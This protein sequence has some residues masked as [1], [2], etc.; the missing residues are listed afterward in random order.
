MVIIDTSIWVEAFRVTGSFARRELEGLLRAREAAGIGIIY[1]EVLRGAR[2]EDDF[3]R[4]LERFDAVPFIDATKST[5]VLAGRLLSHLA[6]SGALIP[7]P[8]AVI[9]AH[10]LEGDHELFT[11][12]EH[13]R[14]VP[15][16]R[17]HNPAGPVP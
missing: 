4:L 3:D 13:F 5:W 2:T 16:L 1:A 11:R 15:G 10:A 17:L 9:A 12:D 6:R 14:R 7:L 8:D